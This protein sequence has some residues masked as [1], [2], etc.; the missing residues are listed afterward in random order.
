MPKFKVKVTYQYEGEF[1][2]EADSMNHA[3]EIVDKTQP[4]QVVM[5]EMYI[6]GVI[7]WEIQDKP[8]ITI[9]NPKPIV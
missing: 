9:D 1:T 7:N 3:A 6:P 4:S 5:N 8:K 2:V